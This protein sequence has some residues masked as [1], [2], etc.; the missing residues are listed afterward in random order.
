MTALL[1]MLC[2]EL[3]DLG[4][5]KIMKAQRGRL[6]VKGTAPR[7][8]RFFR[9]GLNAIVPY[10][11]HTAEDDTLWKKFGPLIVAGAQLPQDRNERIAN[12]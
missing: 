12:E 10:I 4:A 8:H 2:I 1:R 11:A 9:V 5:G 7:D 6:N 3:F